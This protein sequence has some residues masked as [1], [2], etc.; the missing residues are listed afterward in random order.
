MFATIDQATDYIRDHLQEFYDQSR[1]LRDRLLAIGTLRRTAKEAGDTDAYD[2]LAAI[3]TQTEQ[4]FRDQLALEQ[5]LMPFARY[6]GTKTDLAA[7]PLFA[8]GIAVSAAG[9]LYL[10]FQK[11]R[12]QKEALR[13]VAEGIMTPA[14]AERVMEAG[15][16]IGAGGLTELTGNIGMILLLVVGGFVVYQVMP[17]RT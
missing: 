13:Q 3:R 1:V 5:R 4:L 12:N 11:I 8:V 17:K 14:E 7:V 9:A 10:H 16:L 6:F 2:K 15:G